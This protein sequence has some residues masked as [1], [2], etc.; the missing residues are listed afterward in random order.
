M[1]WLE[2]C[3]EQIHEG[4]IEWWLLIHPLTDVSDVATC[5]LA[6]HWTVE[7]SES[8]ICPPAPMILNIGQ[9]LNEDREKCR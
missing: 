9:F 1:R 5:T 8:P 7:T 4:E 3:E 2:Q 6:W